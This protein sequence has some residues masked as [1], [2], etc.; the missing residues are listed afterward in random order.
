M[1][2]AFTDGFTVAGRRQD[3]AAIPMLER[4]ADAP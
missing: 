2:R 1:A 4:L 3:A